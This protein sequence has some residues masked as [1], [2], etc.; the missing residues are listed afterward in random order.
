MAVPVEAQSPPST[1]AIAA[2]VDGEPRAWPRVAYLTAMRAAMIWPG[3]QLAGIRGR[4]ALAGAAVGSVTI[5]LLLLA[6]YSLKQ[7]NHR[8]R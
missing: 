2:V 1:Y 7:T 8:T 6:N 5:T 3:L 4:D